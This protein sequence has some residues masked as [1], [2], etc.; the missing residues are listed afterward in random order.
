MCKSGALLIPFTFY[1]LDLR[2]DIIPHAGATRSISN[3]F[4]RSRWENFFLILMIGALNTI[5]PISID[6]YLPAFPKIAADLH[7]SIGNVSLSASTYFLGFALGQILYG[8]LLD[9]FG[10]KRPLYIGLCCYILAT[11]ACAWS[12]SI[13]M[14]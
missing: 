9:R 4:L 14:L 3:P 11:L 1:P 10:R 6:M 13:E 5:T 8:P 7:S 12:A 2:M